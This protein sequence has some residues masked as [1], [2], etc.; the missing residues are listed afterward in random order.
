MEG[1][2]CS[3]VRDT[4]QGRVGRDVTSWT[5]P[6]GTTTRARPGGVDGRRMAV[7]RSRLVQVIGAAAAISRVSRAQARRRQDI[8]QPPP[9][10]LPL[11]RNACRVTA[12]SFRSRECCGAANL[13]QASSILTICSCYR[14]V[15][16]RHPI[17]FQQ[18]HAVSAGGQRDRIKVHCCP[19]TPPELSRSTLERL[20]HIP[21]WGRRQLA[22]SSFQSAPRRF[23]PGSGS[24][25]DSSEEIVSPLMPRKPGQQAPSAATASRPPGCFSCHPVLPSSISGDPAAR[26]SRTPGVV[27]G[28]CLLVLQRRRRG[29]SGQCGPDSLFAKGR[30]PSLLLH[31]QVQWCMGGLFCGP[32]LD[33]AWT[34]SGPLTNPWPPAHGSGPRMRLIFPT[35]ARHLKIG[36]LVRAGSRDDEPWQRHRGGTVVL[37]LRRGARPSAK[38]TS[39]STDAMTASCGTSRLG[40]LRSGS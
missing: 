25:Q 32:L 7:H 10:A 6:S 1:S 24:C 40:H 18:V 27:D 14:S 3:G 35:Q 13:R 22:L 9:A 23:E 36:E 19:D 37:T 31:R 17:R 8:L 38:S 29:A 20:R 4:P 33:L 15:G 21:A 26:L 16:N 2:G 39:G 11:F 30:A 34:A 5:A 12:L 28:G